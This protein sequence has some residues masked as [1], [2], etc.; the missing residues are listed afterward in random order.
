MLGKVVEVSTVI[1]T[2]LTYVLVHIWSSRASFK[3]G[4]KPAGDNAFVMD[5]VPGEDT[6]SDVIANI[7]G[8]LSRRKSNGAYPP[9]H[10][11][12]SIPHGYADPR[13]ILLMTELLDIEVSVK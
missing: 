8:Y 11:K 10:A 7:E 1:D 6:P 2:P 9:F 12:P 13:G 5:L 3:R 4:D